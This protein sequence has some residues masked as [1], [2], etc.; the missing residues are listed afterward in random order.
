MGG[1]EGK[2][3]SGQGEEGVRVTSPGQGDGDVG[4]KGEGGNK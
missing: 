4:V 3:L 1:G 2:A